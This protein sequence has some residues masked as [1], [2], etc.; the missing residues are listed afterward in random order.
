MMIHYFKL[1][2]E[3]CLSI[4]EIPIAQLKI[5]LIGTNWPYLQLTFANGLSIP[6]LN[7]KSKN[8]LLSVDFTY[9][10]IIGI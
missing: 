1:I 9:H 7:G 5:E 2:L 3:N 8:K 6:L 10:L 4:T